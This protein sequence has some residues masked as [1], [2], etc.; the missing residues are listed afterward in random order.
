[1]SEL[2][3]FVSLNRNPETGTVCR[4]FETGYANVGATVPRAVPPLER[5]P[6]HSIGWPKV[7]EAV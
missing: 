1:M 6:A 2:V 5:P 3:T 4:D 7:A